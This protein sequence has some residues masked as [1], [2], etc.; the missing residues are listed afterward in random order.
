MT[1]TTSSLLP[2]NPDELAELAA[3]ARAHNTLHHSDSRNVLK[4]RVVRMRRRL[5]P[6]SVSRLVERYEAGENTPVLS[7]EFGISRS[8]LC[9]LLRSEGVALRRRPLDADVRQRAES[10]YAQG[11]SIRLVASTVG[12]SY[13]TVRRTLRDAGVPIRKS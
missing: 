3:M 1:S 12:Y 9:T 4:V 6:E 8:S 2:P 10:L 5:S 7:Q 11:S 13:G